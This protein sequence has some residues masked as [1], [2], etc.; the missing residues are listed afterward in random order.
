[1]GVLFW[2]TNDSILMCRGVILT[3]FIDTGLENKY[4]V[5]C[6]Q[7]IQWMI[8]HRY[9]LDQL[10]GRQSIYALYV[11]H[12]MHKQEYNYYDTCP[13]ITHLY[14]YMLDTSLYFKTFYQP[15]QIH[16]G[17]FVCVATH[18]VKLLSLLSSAGNHRRRVPLRTTFHTM[19]SHWIWLFWKPFPRKIFKSHRCLR[20]FHFIFYE[21]ID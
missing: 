2:F 20:L 16:W 5:V 15:I 11:L 1:M 8:H 12:L 7:Y 17:T 10:K 21:N 13:M 4:L 6:W 19:K 3:K 9:C 14:L 18:K